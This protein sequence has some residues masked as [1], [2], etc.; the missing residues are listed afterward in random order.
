MARSAIGTENGD[1]MRRRWAPAVACAALAAGAALAGCAT[2]VTGSARPAAPVTSTAPTTTPTPTRRTTLDCSGGTVIHPHGAPYCYLLPAG[3]ADATDQLTLT[4]QSATPGRYDSAVSVAVHDVV[5][6]VVY[7]LRLDSDGFGQSQLAGAV[8]DVLRQG[9]SSGFT[10]VGDPTPT[11]VTGDRA[12]RV[13][14]KQNQGQYTA[15]IYFVFDGFT[16]VEIGCQSAQRPQD[17]ARGCAG[18][19]STVQ[20]IDP[21][22]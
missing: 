13:P 6:V 17:V 7:P 8:R 3:F 16:E 19:L 18:V 10:V 1:T 4:Y 20:I 15:T 12:F 14:V 2:T 11:T 5:L 22:R 9:E 21:P